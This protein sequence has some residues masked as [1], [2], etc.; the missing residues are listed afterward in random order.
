[1]YTII[2]PS[3]GTDRPLQTVDPDQVPQNAVTDQQVYTD[4]HTYN[5]ILDTSRGGRMDYFE[6]SD[7][8]GK[9]IRCSNT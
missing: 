4:C 8:Y 2:I 6:F 9:E 7:K 3:I 5:N 1:M